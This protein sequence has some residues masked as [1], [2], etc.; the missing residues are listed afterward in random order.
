MKYLERVA[1]V[2]LFVPMAIISGVSFVLAVTA[3]IPMLVFRFLTEGPGQADK[4]LDW[5]M[6]QVGD[7][8]LLKAPFVVWL[9]SIQRRTPKR[10]DGTEA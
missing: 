9:E 8:F 10:T 2:V 4:F 3:V 5:W 6:N 1:F 7:K